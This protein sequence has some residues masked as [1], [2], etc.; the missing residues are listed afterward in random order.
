MSIRILC[1]GDLVGTPGCALFQKYAQRLKREYKAEAIIV[2]GENAAAN[3]RG[4]TQKVVASLCH[5]GADMITGGNHSFQ[6]NDILPYFKENP[7]NL[8]RPANFPGGCPG[9]G[10]GIITTESGVRIGVI[11]VLG[12]I[13]MRQHVDCPFKSVES[14]LTF[15]KA[16][17]N[18][19]VVDMH[20]EA[21]SEKIAMGLY[22]DGKI[23]AVIGTHTHVPTA[24]ERILPEGT[25]FISDLGMA[26]SLNGMIGMKKDLMINHLL[27]QMPT[28]FEVDTQPPF[29]ISGVCIEVDEKSGKTTSIEQ[30]RII[31]DELTFG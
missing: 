29:V 11:N 27:L 1:F 20:A 21:T 17:T 3:G 30:F 16:Q 15:L 28:R 4:I 9:R 14:A 23:S 18:I 6:Q 12:R 5:S 7:A 31:D 26:G 22:F 25:G 19:I 8:L 13:Y 2:N 10:V 24:D